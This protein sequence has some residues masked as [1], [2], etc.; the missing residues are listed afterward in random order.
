MEHA[1]IQMNEKETNEYVE[2]FPSLLKYK[3][4]YV[5]FKRDKDYKFMDETDKFAF[6]ERMKCRRDKLS[7]IEYARK[8]K[9]TLKDVRKKKLVK[10]CT[11]FPTPMVLAVLKMF[12]AKKWLDPTAG[13]GDR[14][15]GALLANIEKYV[16]IDSNKDLEKVYNRIKDY[17]KDSKTDATIHISKFQNTTQKIKSKFDLVFTSPPFS[18]LEIYEHMN[19]TSNSEFIETFMNPFFEFSIQKLKLNGHLV[20]YIENVSIKYLLEEVPKLFPQL[21][22]EGMFYYEGIGKPRPYYVW[23]KV[24]STK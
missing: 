18:M 9:M 14:L 2:K 4:K 1:A 15:R 17:Y 24:K 6:E 11:L 19:V 10:E 12:K 22:F 13:W 8:H 23:K 20:L 16:G 5:I 7:P 3:K 21:K